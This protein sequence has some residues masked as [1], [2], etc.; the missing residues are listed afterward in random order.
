MK[1]SSMS[2]VDIV[3]AVAAWSASRS[4]GLSCYGFV[5]A[6]HACSWDSQG[7]SPRGAR[8]QY[9]VAV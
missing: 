9:G 3:R 6:C 8:M 4:L 2:S 7:R 5:G 1:Y